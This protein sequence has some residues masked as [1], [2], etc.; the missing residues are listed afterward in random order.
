VSF[1]PKVH[2]SLA[3][4]ATRTVLREG[5]RDMEERISKIPEWVPVRDE[6]TARRSYP[7]LRRFFD[8]T[9]IIGRVEYAKKHSSIKIVSLEPRRRGEFDELYASSTVAGNGIFQSKWMKFRITHHAIDRFQQRHSGVLQDLETL[10]DEFAPTVIA[11]TTVE[12]EKPQNVLLPAVH[13][14]CIMSFEEGSGERYVST[15]LSDNE[16]R[17]EQLAER[18]RLMERVISLACGSALPLARRGTFAGRN[19]TVECYLRSSL[20]PR[21]AARALS[22]QK[23]K[24]KS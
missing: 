3:R 4:G 21:V 20:Q 11:G 18:E 7:V 10:I 1:I 15:Y 24:N 13:G 17:P 8:K 6:R 5:R 12:E 2:A 19:D 9:T 14:A 23:A 16:L 22:H